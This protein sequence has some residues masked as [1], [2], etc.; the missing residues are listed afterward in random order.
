M[1]GD[2]G[3]SDIARFKCGKTEETR[4]AEEICRVHRCDGGKG[5]VIPKPVQHMTCNVQ[6]GRKKARIKGKARG[7]T[8]VFDTGN[9]RQ[10]ICAGVRSREGQQG[11]E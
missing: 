5:G 9:G 8:T 6:K 3:L 11:W 4:K 2:A 7:D 10:M 1:V